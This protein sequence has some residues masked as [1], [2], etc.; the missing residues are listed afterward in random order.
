MSLLV[1]DSPY[2]DV[3]S[4]PY[5][6]RQ[7]RFSQVQSL[8]ERTL[9][10]RGSCRILDVGGEA[11]YWEMARDYLSERN[12]HVT[13]LNLTRQR[14]ASPQFA[15]EKGDATRLDHLSDMAYDLVHSNSVIE[16]VGNWEAMTSMARHV[17]RLAPRYFVQTPNFWFPIEP[18]VRAPFFHWLPEQVR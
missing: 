8:I 16:H 13:L 9:Q 4:L 1:L 11:I 14:V 15:S 3:R 6:F 5:R 7:K 2:E 17:R 10:E 18:H 12:V